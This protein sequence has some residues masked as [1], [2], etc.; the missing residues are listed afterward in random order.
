[1]HKVLERKLTPTP[2][3]VDVELYNAGGDINWDEL[4]VFENLGL[5][6]LALS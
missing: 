2:A 1:M 4:Y 6:L 3:Y 5:F